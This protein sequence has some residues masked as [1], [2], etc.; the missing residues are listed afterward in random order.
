[1][2]LESCCRRTGA[3]PSL[4]QRLAS[5]TSEDNKTTT[6]EE[7]A[8]KGPTALVLPNQDCSTIERMFDVPLVICEIENY[9]FDLKNLVV[10][11]GHLLRRY[12]CRSKDILIIQMVDQVVRGVDENRFNLIVDGLN[13]LLGILEAMKLVRKQSNKFSVSPP[14]LNKP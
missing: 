6:D 11:V 2:L 14:E 8:D 9:T 13:Q 10:M 3:L 1:M 5:T 12:C 4:F 7:S